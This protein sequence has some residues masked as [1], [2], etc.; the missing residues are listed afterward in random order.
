MSEENPS[1]SCP[2]HAVAEKWWAPANMRS[3]EKT[4]RAPCS[5]P[6]L[7]DGLIWKGTFKICTTLQAECDSDTNDQNKGWQKQGDHWTKSITGNFCF[8]MLLR[9]IVWEAVAPEK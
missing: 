3:W 5:D 2:L 9:Y 4:L 8:H 7:P 1:R 6:L